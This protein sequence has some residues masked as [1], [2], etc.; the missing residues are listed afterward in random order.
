M[1][2][3]FSVLP[4]YLG[5]P[6]PPKVQNGFIGQPH[7]ARAAKRSDRGRG[8]TGA[9][10]GYGREKDQRPREAGR[11]GITGGGEDVTPVGR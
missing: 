11:L 1:M 2:S 5:V 6:T 8:P 7:D 9:A 10:D 4:N 3:F